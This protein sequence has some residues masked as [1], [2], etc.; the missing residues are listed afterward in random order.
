MSSPFSI[1]EYTPILEINCKCEMT[2]ELERTA[3]YNNISEFISCW[4]N[5]IIFSEGDNTYDSTG[6]LW[7]N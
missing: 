6:Y 2:E 3:F 5:D 7:Q 4:F 1:G